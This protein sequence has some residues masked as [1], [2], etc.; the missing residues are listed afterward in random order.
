MV[1]YTIKRFL[2]AW[3]TLIVLIT[4]S[5][6]LMRVAPGGPFSG[7]KVLSAAVQANLDA[8]YHLND[9]IFVQYLDYLWSLAR[10]D[11]GPSFKYPDWTVNQ[12]INQGFP[13]SLWIGGW[14]MFIAIII[15][16]L[17]GSLAAF[18]QN[19]WVDYI[20]TGMSMT[21]IS[22]PS[23]VT[24]PMFTLLFAVVLGWVPAGGW[25]DGAFLNM[26][27]PV[28]ALALPQIA[29]ISRIMRGS[30]I[31]VLR[32][33]YIRTAKA[34]GIPNRIIL[35][36]HAIRPAIL[37]VISYLG[38]ATAGIITGSVV[39]EQIFSLPGLGSYLVKGALNRDYTLVLGSVILVGALIIAFNFIV[40]VLYAM[41]DPKI[42]Y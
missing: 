24:A 25:N 9:P 10:G 8:K 39:V 14:A 37:P 2:G 23:F 16:V 7:E 26:I 22:I 27:L 1:S 17:V 34:K 20:A 12:L 40:D 32:S 30:M 11:F 38:P 29:I 15:G 18:K 42:K 36:R 4:L 28:T 41:I 21:G 13:V 5:F 35:F 6:F 31:E 3:P 19:T 33:N